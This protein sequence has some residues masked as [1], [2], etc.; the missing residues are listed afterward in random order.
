MT[1]NHELERDRQVADLRAVLRS[2]AEPREDDGA[3][4][5]V[6]LD[7]FGDG[8]EP[9]RAAWRAR[10]ARQRGSVAVFVLVAVLAAG[11]TA[12]VTWF[13]RPTPIPVP[14][15]Q[16]AVVVSDEHNDRA[17]PTAPAPAADQEQTTSSPPIVV[18]VIGHVVAPGL[19]TLP[20]GAR[21]SDAIAAAGGALPGTDLTTINIARKVSDGEQIAVG[22]PGAVD[23]GAA[24]QSGASAA[25]TGPVDINNANLQQLDQLP[26]IGPVTAQSIIDFR[27]Q[28]GP[29]GAVADLA[30]VSGIGPATMAKLADLVT[31]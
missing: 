7:G 22:V 12:L 17:G 8:F 20:D 30:N 28:N 27:E 11:A 16:D 21:V 18:A 4:E 15:S 3:V 5:T 29:F 9:P 10:L 25:G 2:S 19:V 24:A 14:A 31:V 23:G 1:R 26:G 13:L 6:T